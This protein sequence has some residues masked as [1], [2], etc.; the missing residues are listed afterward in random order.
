[1]LCQTTGRYRVG[2]LHGKERYKV[3]PESASLLGSDPRM[4]PVCDFKVRGDALPPAFYTL[5][6]RDNTESGISIQKIRLMLNC[7]VSG[8]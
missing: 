6:L 7:H 5:Y 3:H 1:M 4:K 2:V 8:R